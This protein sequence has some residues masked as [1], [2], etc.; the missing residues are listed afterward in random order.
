M[1]QSL[2]AVRHQ[3]PG[4]AKKTPSGCLICSPSLPQAFATG[5]D[6]VVGLDNFNRYYPV[7]LKRARQSQLRA[8]NGV[9]ILDADLNNEAAL[10]AM[11]RRCNITH[12]IH[13][14]AQV[15]ETVMCFSPN[16]MQACRMRKLGSCA[17]CPMILYWCS[18]PASTQARDIHHHSGFVY[19]PG[20][21]GWQ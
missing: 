16:R 9:W 2:Q 4:T 6:F 10:N 15:G 13:L 21:L 18:L 1:Q 3:A 7:S 12:V 11:F 14:A 19:L 17:I 20:R 8:Q 5:G